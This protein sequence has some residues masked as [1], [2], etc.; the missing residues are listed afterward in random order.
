MANVDLNVYIITSGNLFHCVKMAGHAVQ[1][2][3]KNAS[4]ALYDCRPGF[5]QCYHIQTPSTART[6][7]GHARKQEPVGTG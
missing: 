1:L 4:Q 5:G 2:I 3:S 7:C 6:I